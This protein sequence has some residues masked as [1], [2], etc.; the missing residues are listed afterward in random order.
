MKKPDNYLEYNR[1]AWNHQVRNGN[2]WTVPFSDDV[3][4]AAKKGQINLV[5]TPQRVVPPHWY[6]PKGSKVLGLA[7]G[8]GQQGPVL[9]AAGYDV[10]IFDNSSAQ[11]EQDR[12]MSEKFNLGIKTVQGDMAD[13]TVFA[14]ETFDMIFNPCSTGFVPDVVKVYAEAARVL[15]KGGIFM[16]GFIK[17]VYYLFDIKLAEKGIF[18]LKYKSPYSDLE[19]LDESELNFFLEQNEPVVFGHSMEAHINGQLKAGLQFTEIMEDTWGENN[20]ADRYFP[21]FIA[22]RAVKSFG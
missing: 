18:T 14:D 11:L 15:K 20:A 3:I 5:L 16:T 8:G 7:S 2:R 17:P 4:E 21:S 6:A 22:A 10:T 19:S 1:D 9:A 13:L 12:I